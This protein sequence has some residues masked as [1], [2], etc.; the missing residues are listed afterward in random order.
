M[1]KTGFKLSAARYSVSGGDTHH[2]RVI[3]PTQIKVTRIVLRRDEDV[4]NS[5]IKGYKYLLP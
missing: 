5:Q 1:A 3:S 4:R 2:G